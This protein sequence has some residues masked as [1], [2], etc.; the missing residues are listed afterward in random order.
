MPGM[1]RPEEGSSAGAAKLVG[2]DPVLD[3]VNTVGG[4]LDG[5]EGS[6]VLRDKLPAYADLLAWAQHAG[7]VPAA[8]A[9]ALLVLARRRPRR[10]AAVMAR[11]RR[12]R[13]ALYRVL[14]ALM[15]GEPPSAADL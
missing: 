13:E 1:E 5:D 3:F 9:R 2:G 11:A 8:E 6:V 12:W 4:R 7:V 14:L 10:A 15:E